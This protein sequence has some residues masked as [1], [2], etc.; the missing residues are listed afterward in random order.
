MRRRVSNILVARGP[1][2][3]KIK[4]RKKHGPVSLVLIENM[5]SHEIFKVFVVRDD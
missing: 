1:D 4:F 2:E 5:R 3:M